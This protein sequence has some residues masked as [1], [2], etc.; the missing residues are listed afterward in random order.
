MDA[1]GNIY[2]VTDEV[3]II[4]G[5]VPTEIDIDRL[6]GYI[7]ARAERDRAKRA[8]VLE[9]VYGPGGRLLWD[10]KNQGT[11]R[12]EQSMGIEGIEKLAGDDDPMDPVPA[13]EEEEPSIR[14]PFET[15]EV[16]PAEEDSE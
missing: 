11:Y 1:H 8:K 7:E 13:T 15:G 9:K 16:V 14:P 10:S 6:H 12:K 2:E 4:Q 5:D 3:R